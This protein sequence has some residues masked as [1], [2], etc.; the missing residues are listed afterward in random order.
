MDKN[1]SSVLNCKNL[2]TGFTT[3]ACATAAAAAACKALCRGNF[4]T[5]VKIT[6]PKKQQVQFAVSRQEIGKGWARASVIKDAGDDPDVTHGS[7]VIVTLR[8]HNTSQ[9]NITF[10]A[11]DGIGRVT[12]P[13]LQLAV[14][15]AA[16]N[17]V[18]RRMITEAITTVLKRHGRPNNGLD[19][20]VSIPNGEMLALKT[21]NKRL[22]I[23]GGLSI[24]GTSGIVIPYSCSAW[25]DSI[26]RSI[27]VARACKLHHLLASTGSTSENAVLKRMSFAVEA[28]VNMGN[29][30]GDVLKYLYSRPVKRLT[31]AGGF[32]KIT[33]L[34]QGHLNLHSSRSQI[35]IAELA[36]WIAALSNDRALFTAVQKV[37]TVKQVFGILSPQARFKLGH[38]IARRAQAI[39][40][41]VI[42]NKFQ[43]DILMIDQQG[44][45]LGYAD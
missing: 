13:G 9:K 30:V 14:G 40:N 29:F 19:I 43:V 23:T 28:R 34:A 26:Y 15:E 2:R 21:L 33:K 42:E 24:L 20:T 18:P 3:G 36:K 1:I 8:P 7:E 35:N 32:A 12:R 38:A 45:I 10:L 11:G 44:K 5:T 17:P 22:G 41:S 39:A 31:I 27:D 25:I 6:L 37:D 4:S 16:I